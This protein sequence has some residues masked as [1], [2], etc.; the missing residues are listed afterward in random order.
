M[1]V[2][3]FVS[4]ARIIF[5]F[6]VMTT[7]SLRPTA[8]KS[9]ILNGESLLPFYELTKRTHYFFVLVFSYMLFYHKRTLDYY[10]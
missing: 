9:S 1:A 10:W 7:T 8:L 6:D 4:F 5:G 3:T 2:I